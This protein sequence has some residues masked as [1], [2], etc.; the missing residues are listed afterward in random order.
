MPHY[1]VQRGSAERRLSA[2]STAYALWFRDVRP[3]SESG[4][5]SNGSAR[6]AKLLHGL[7]PNMTLASTYTWVKPKYFSSHSV[8]RIR[9][10]LRKNCDPLSHTLL[11]TIS[12]TMLRSVYTLPGRAPPR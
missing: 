7:S 6:S 9:I 10:S 5:L 12:Q 11:I 2:L 4:N 1:L 8:T 3:A